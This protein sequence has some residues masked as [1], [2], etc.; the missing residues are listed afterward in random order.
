MSP[1]SSASR[2]RQTSAFTLMELLVAMAILGILLVASAG[3]NVLLLLVSLGS[4]AGGGLAGGQ[5][6]DSALFDEVHVAG[7]RGGSDKVLQIG[8][9]GAIA[10]GQSALIGAAGGTVGI[11]TC[12]FPLASIQSM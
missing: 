11:I 2:T 12:A 9:R 4:L 7:E 5:D 3:L 10:E 1:P 6:L 8:I